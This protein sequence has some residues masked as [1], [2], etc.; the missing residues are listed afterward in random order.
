MTLRT[1]C[2]MALR[3]EQR[4]RCCKDGT[5]L[6]RLLYSSFFFFLSLLSPPLELGRDRRMVFSNLGSLSRTCWRGGRWAKESITVSSSGPALS[7]LRISLARMS[8][9]LWEAPSLTKNV[10][11]SSSRSTRFSDLPGSP[12]TTTSSGVLPGSESNR[13]INKNKP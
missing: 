11:I 13:K 9:S 1:R 12:Y 2:L 3:M 6:A 10:A 4:A 8:S 7:L 5:R